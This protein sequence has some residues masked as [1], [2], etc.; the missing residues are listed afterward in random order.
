MFQFS[1]RPG[2]I[3]PQA[4]ERKKPPLGV[5]PR[6]RVGLPE[7]GALAAGHIAGGAGLAVPPIA[8][9]LRFVAAEDLG[10]HCRQ[11]PLLHINGEEAP[12]HFLGDVGVAAAGGE[13]VPHQGQDKSIVVGVGIFPVRPAVPGLHGVYVVQNGPERLQ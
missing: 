12:P 2:R 7:L 11:R 10:F 8:P 9:P 3:L 5:G 4:V 6:P 1:E 13:F